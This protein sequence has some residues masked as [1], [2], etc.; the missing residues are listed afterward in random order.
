MSL[1]KYIL[2][3]T[4][5]QIL[6]NEGQ[7]E[8]IINKIGLS[9]HLADYCV[10]TFDKKFVL[11][12][13]TTIK[14]S[15][16]YGNGG[17][18]LKPNLEYMDFKT[19]PKILKLR[20]LEDHMMERILPDLPKNILKKFKEDPENPHTNFNIA[21]SYSDMYVSIS[22]YAHVTHQNFQGADFED[23]YR[24]S[25]TWHEEIEDG[26]TSK[27]LQLQEDQEII[28]EFSDGYY[29]VNL[30]DNACEDEGDSMG[31]CGYTSADTL[32]SLRDEKGVPHVTL[33]CTYHGTQSIVIYQMKGKGNTKPVKKYH[34]YIVDLLIDGEN[35]ASEV[36]GHNQSYEVVDYKP[37]YMRYDDFNIFDLDE[38][39]INQLKQEGAYDRLLLAWISEDVLYNDEAFQENVINDVDL[40][41]DVFKKF[42]LSLP[43]AFSTTFEWE[44]YFDKKSKTFSVVANDIGRMLL[45][46]VMEDSK[47]YDEI[48]NGNKDV[49][50]KVMWDNFAVRL[51]DVE[52]NGREYSFEVPN[53]FGI[54]WV[55][56]SE[57]IINEFPFNKPL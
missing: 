32:L 50:D 41:I 7:K 45:D 54:E 13:A 24:D 48:K 18:L 12:W 3:N 14:N 8:T 29:W 11:Y 9:K 10:R 46:F 16:S 22:D 39:Y 35:Y 23:T 34:P 31:H 37:E 27:A 56:A 2:E 49:M 20:S 36:N 53:Y 52:K 28:K 47:E 19:N 30:G 44:L 15:L 38:K 4:C 43:S 26:G 40:F 5:V 21:E 17:E 6:L 57:E 33:A 42:D 25:V 55:L 51:E 1:K